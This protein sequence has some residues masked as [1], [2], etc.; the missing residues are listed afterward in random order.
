MAP[1]RGLGDEQREASPMR[2]D[3]HARATFSR[4]PI[5]RSP[6]IRVPRQA[7][8]VIPTQPGSRPVPLR[9]DEVRS[10][11]CRRNDIVALTLRWGTTYLV[12]IP[13]PYTQEQDS[14]P[15]PGIP[16]VATPH[17]EAPT[18]LVTAIERG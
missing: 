11:S 16:D 15:L 5:L 2:N 8:R 14:S 17:Q 1:R 9:D 4:R 13:P 12:P 18:D 7:K 6:A 10:R 3:A